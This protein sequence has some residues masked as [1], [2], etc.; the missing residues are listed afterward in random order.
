MWTPWFSTSGSLTQA[1]INFE[2]ECVMLSVRALW[3]TYTLSTQNKWVKVVTEIFCIDISHRRALMKPC[4]PY[5]KAN[6]LN[7]IWERILKKIRH[8]FPC[9]P[10]IYNNDSRYHLH[11]SDGGLHLITIKRFRQEFIKVKLIMQ[12]PNNGIIRLSVLQ[13]K[14]IFVGLCLVYSRPKWCGNTHRPNLNSYI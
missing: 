2:L 12:R 9:R 3:S 8:I 13:E 10:I 4:K 5:L 7:D 6:L 1:Q 11:R 14:R